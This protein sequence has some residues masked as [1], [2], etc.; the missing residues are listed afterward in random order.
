MA[1]D[2][3]AVVEAPVPAP[4]AAPKPSLDQLLDQYTQLRANKDKMTADEYDTAGR[5]LRRKIRAAG[6][7]VNSLK[8]EAEAKPAKE[9]KAP[10]APKAKKSRSAN[11]EAGLDG[12]PRAQPAGLAHVNWLQKIFSGEET[13]PEDPQVTPLKF[14]S[15]ED[16]EASG[17]FGYGIDVLSD[18][19]PRQTIAKF[20]DRFGYE[21]T[22]FAI[23]RPESYEIPTALTLLI[24]GPAPAG[25]IT[26]SDAETAAVEETDTEEAAAD[27]E[28]AWGEDAEE[29][30]A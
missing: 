21:P 27:E 4:A 23:N 1:I 29:D 30:E 14:R 11:V 6:G 10:K 25:E 8:P 28:D 18:V 16:L 26:E 3:T 15:M 13:L 20:V 5:T 2:E 12:D 7:S 22:W 19:L 17:D 24:L 9:P